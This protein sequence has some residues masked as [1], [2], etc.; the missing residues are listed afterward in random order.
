MILKNNL[1]IKNIQR[2]TLA[3]C[4]VAV[5]FFCNCRSVHTISD[6]LCSGGRGAPCRTRRAF[7]CLANRLLHAVPC[8]HCVGF[9]WSQTAPGGAWWKLIKAILGLQTWWRQVGD[10]ESF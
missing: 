8:S 6:W 4:A 7:V 1:F 2:G 3:F 10:H 9:P 5:P